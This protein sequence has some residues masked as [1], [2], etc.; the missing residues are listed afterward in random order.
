AAAIAA[1]ADDDPVCRASLQLYERRLA[2]ALASVVNLFDPEAI[3]LGG[4]LSGIAALYRAVP[5]LWGQFVFSDRVITRLL[6]PRHG[7]SSG[8]RGA[9]RLWDDNE[10][11]PRETPS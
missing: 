4:G 2:R 7:D 8:V 9:A 11:H 6:A 3:V 10:Q 1:A 5:A